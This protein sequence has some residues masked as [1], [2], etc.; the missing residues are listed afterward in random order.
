MSADLRFD[1]QREGQGKSTF[2]E[3]NRMGRLRQ[4][5]TRH[6]L[7]SVTDA[8][9]LLPRSFGGTVPTVWGQLPILVWGPG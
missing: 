8:S 9:L 2:W 5:G 4:R 1:T 6:P 3:I 7:Q